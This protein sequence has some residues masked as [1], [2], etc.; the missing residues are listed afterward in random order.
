MHISHWNII[1]YF[2]GFH[3]GAQTIWYSNVVP[4]SKSIRAK[5]QYY[6]LHSKEGIFHAGD[7]HLRETMEEYWWGVVGVGEGVFVSPGD[8]VTLGIPSQ[9]FAEFRKYDIRR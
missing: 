8:S 3:T 5:H 2:L 4:I 9:Q 1:G 7:H 6:T